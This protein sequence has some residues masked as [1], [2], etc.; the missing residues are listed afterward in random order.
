MK[1]LNMFK[2]F[3]WKV[4]TW[5]ISVSD[6]PFTVPHSSITCLIRSVFTFC[7]FSSAGWRINYILDKLNFEETINNNLGWKTDGMLPAFTN[8]VES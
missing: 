6:K 5:S 4:Q 2:I 7:N 3:L 1:L 8:R